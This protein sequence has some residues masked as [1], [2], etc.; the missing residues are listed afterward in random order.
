M[1]SLAIRFHPVARGRRKSPWPRRSIAGGRANRRGL[2]SRAAVADRACPYCNAEVSAAAKTCPGCGKKLL[3]FKLGTDETS[4]TAGTIK[5]APGSESPRPAARAR[6][7]RTPLP[8]KALV[9]FL[10]ILIIAGAVA[11]SAISSHSAARD[12]VV[13]ESKSS[14]GYAIVRDLRKHG[15][16]STFAAVEPKSGWDS[17]YSLDGGDAHLFFRGTTDASFT[18]SASASSDLS[19]AIEAAFTRAGWHLK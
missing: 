3:Y 1:P 10:P 2:Y 14:P 18:V 6:S 9:R 17:E 5:K 16:I 4:K 7:P 12:K 15:A 8:A 13:P 19:T 11:I